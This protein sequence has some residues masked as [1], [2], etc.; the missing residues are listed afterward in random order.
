V[1]H[2]KCV[3]DALP[4]G[5]WQVQFLDISSSL[6]T[7]GYCIFSF[8]ILLYNS[9]IV[10]V[11]VCDH[12]MQYTIINNKFFLCNCCSVLLLLSILFE[13]GHMS[14]NK[15]SQLTDGSY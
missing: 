9:L 4:S 15:I 7:R 11:H 14:V 13:E 6:V 12:F 3:V 2:L 10:L 1:S 8:V 5:S